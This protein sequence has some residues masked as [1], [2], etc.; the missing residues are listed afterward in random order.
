MECHPFGKSGNVEQEE[1]ESMNDPHPSLEESILL[2]GGFDGCSWLS[3]MDCYHPSID[4]MESRSSMRLLRS[5]ASAANLNG[6]VYVFGGVYDNV[7]Y[8][9]GSS[10]NHFFQFTISTAS[11]EF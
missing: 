4:H 1:S 9:E 8:D 6:E 3:A 5:Y 2:V 10:S 11:Y 7:W